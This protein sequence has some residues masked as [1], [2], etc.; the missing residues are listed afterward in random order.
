MRIGAHVPT[1]GGLFGAID[2]ARACG[3]DA[4][5]IW[6]SNPRSW[7]HP[8]VRADV[9]DEF[10]RAWRE[11][12]LGPLFLHAPY[13][14]N[15]ASP[16]REF[17]RRSVDLARATV[18][19]AE[20]I[21]ATG[22]VV[23]AGSAGTAIERALAVEVAAGSLH[24]IAAEAE[25]TRVFVELTAGGAGSIGST[26]PE[27]RQLLAAADRHP[28]LALCADTCHLFAAGYALDSSDGVDA[29][30]GELRRLGIARRL[31]LLHANDSRFPLGSHRD[32][33]THIGEG[34]IGLRGFKAI[35]SHP[36]VRRCAVLC[37]T[38]G[39]LE[40][41]ARNIATLRRLARSKA[42]MA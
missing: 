36:A 38:P 27:F 28:R 13:M 26:F 39:R 16:N 12:G 3:A 5:Q 41:H 34:F 20:R 6:G 23:H 22:T 33:H 19:L 21:G 35:L 40:D 4:A 8:S 17:R 15:V 11:A 7:A 29:C 10:G 18:A 9:A 32:S 2:S 1:R 14:V 30:F 42:A 31:G 24:A 37:E 25:G